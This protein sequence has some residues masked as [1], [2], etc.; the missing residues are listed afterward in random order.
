MNHIFGI[1]G[2]F[3]ILVLLFVFLGEDKKSSRTASD[4]GAKGT[5]IGGDFSLTDHH[6]KAVTNKDYA[7]KYMLVY[8]GFTHCPDV[9]PTDILIMSQTLDE[10]GEDAKKITPIFVTI[11]PERDTAASMKNYLSNFHPSIIGLTGTDKQI[12]KAA[13]AYKVFYSRVKDEG[14]ALD[15]TMSHSAYTYFQD[16]EGVYLTHFAHDS[17]PDDIA[18][19][20]KN[21]IK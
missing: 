1:V 4:S 11:D 20:I 7:G 6:G 5:L 18:K 3:F 8:F 21:L 19:K 12:A 17:K 9:C 2:F 14:S 10:L 15:Y 13:L 16:T